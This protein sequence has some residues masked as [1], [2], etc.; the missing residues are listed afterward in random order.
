MSFAGIQ[1]LTYKQLQKTFSGVQN[2]QNQLQM[3]F[4]AIQIFESKKFCK[5]LIDLLIKFK[6]I[7]WIPISSIIA[8]ICLVSINYFYEIS[9][10]V[11]LQILTATH[12]WDKK[13]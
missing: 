7:W 10:T 13:R 5:L 2:I 8:G 4:S 12:I 11:L 3:L 1:I 6:N 9:F